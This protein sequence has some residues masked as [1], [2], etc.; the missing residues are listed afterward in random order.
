MAKKKSSTRTK[1][2]E[3]STKRKR[4]PKY[5][6]VCLV[7]DEEL[8][9]KADTLLEGVEKL[10]LPQFPS[11]PML[12]TFTKGKDELHVNLVVG[13]AKKFMV[14]PSMREMMCE[15]WERQLATL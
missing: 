10:K 11:T 9:S 1:S 2:A 5:D 7:N 15:S 6:L 3:K 13:K 8:K 14:I 4:N 12:F